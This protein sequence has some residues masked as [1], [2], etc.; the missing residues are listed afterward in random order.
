[1]SGLELF[2]GISAVLMCVITLFLVFDRQY[3]DGLFGRVAL[4]AI[5]FAEFA[6]AVDLFSGS[7]DIDLFKVIII[8]QFGVTLFFIR[9]VYR[10]S[11]WR[12]FKKYAW[13]PASRK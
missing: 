4:A 1:M 7:S 5:F 9:H 2:L 12:W 10:F 3:E 13:R 6:L 11:M 8:G